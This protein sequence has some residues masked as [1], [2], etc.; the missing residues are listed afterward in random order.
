[1]PELSEIVLNVATLYTLH[2]HR[3]GR[4]SDA[5][6]ATPTTTQ[7][8]KKRRRHGTRQMCK[9]DGIVGFDPLEVYYH[10][11]KELRKRD[12]ASI[13]DS[14]GTSEGTIS[15]SE[16]TITDEEE[17]RYCR[18]ANEVGVDSEGE[19]STSS[20]DGGRGVFQWANNSRHG[21]TSVTQRRFVA[22]SNIYKVTHI[23]QHLDNGYRK[24]QNGVNLHNK[25]GERPCDSEGEDSDSDTDVFYGD[26]VTREFFND[27]TNDRGPIVWKG[28]E[29]SNKNMVFLF[30]RL[31]EDSVY[32]LPL[33]MGLASL[34]VPELISQD[35][36][37]VFPFNEMKRRMFTI[38]FES[39][40]GDKRYLVALAAQTGITHFRVMPP[41]M[42]DVRRADGGLKEEEPFYL[43]NARP[44]NNV[45]QHEVKEREDLLP[46]TLTKRHTDIAP[47]M[48]SE[49]RS[50]LCLQCLCMSQCTF[51]LRPFPHYQCVVMLGVP[52]PVDF[53]LHL[54]WHFVGGRN[55]GN[56]RRGRDP[57]DGMP[58]R[59][60][61]CALIKD[62][63]DT[64]LFRGFGLRMR[65]EVLATFL[66][67]WRYIGAPID[68]F[69]D[70]WSLLE[71]LVMYGIARWFTVKEVVVGETLG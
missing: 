24:Q 18:E 13:G 69:K 39:P 19:S 53:V 58:L 4:G 59:I 29:M 33:G 3:M 70:R 30:Q 32:C 54:V 71:A 43:A 45:T 2:W 67:A 17:V 65:S 5:H 31:G 35:D 9:K 14:E 62:L 11:T 57:T 27:A 50:L 6:G 52:Q 8:K 10:G 38:A 49:V 63:C 23:E 36:L 25:D 20:D 46:T 15:D 51:M 21:N 40:S 34:F 28:V 12:V 26:E 1:M 41:Q 64:K 37:E 48:I 44:M 60:R 22:P 47:C 7:T 55:G 56:V 16:R 42:K 68:L 61:E 66:D